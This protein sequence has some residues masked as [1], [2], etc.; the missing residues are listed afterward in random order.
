MNKFY[1]SIIGLISGIA[2]MALNNNSVIHAL[3]RFN[4]R[5]FPSEG[6][7][8]NSIVGLIMKAYVIF[9]DLIMFLSLIG[10]VITIIYAFNLFRLML[11]DHKN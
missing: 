3:E 6:V 7:D 5:V 11:K 4:R 8:S 10:S 1:N 2:L 9:Y